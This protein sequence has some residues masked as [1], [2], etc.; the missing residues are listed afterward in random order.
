VEKLKADC[1]NK[2]YYYGGITFSIID[3]LFAA[4]K[5][6]TGDKSGAKYAK[7]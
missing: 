4:V 1:S 5:V 6:D 2:K 3:F 7:E